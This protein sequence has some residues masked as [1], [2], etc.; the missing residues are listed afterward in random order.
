MCTSAPSAP[1][2]SIDWTTQGTRFTLKPASS[3]ATASTIFYNYAYYDSAGS[4][5]EK[6]SSWNSVSGSSES[7]Y[8]A[9]PLPGK[10]KIAFSA[11]A[12]NSCGA[13]SFTRENTTNTG[14]VFSTLIQ[15]EIMVDLTK[16]R[17]QVDSL[18]IPLSTAVSSKHLMALTFS[19]NTEEICTVS[20]SLLTLLK[21]GICRVTV[22]SGSLN[23]I[24]SA[25]KKGVEFQILKAN[26]QISLTIPKS[27]SGSTN[28]ILNPKI[29]ST[30]GLTIESDSPSFCSVR[31]N[32]IIPLATG[33]CV[34]SVTAIEDSNYLEVKKSFSLTI[35]KAENLIEWVIPSINLVDS[36]LQVNPNF[37]FAT[38]FEADN[39]SPEVCQ[40]SE[41]MSVK[42]LKGGYCI[43]HLE[44]KDSPLVFAAT[45]QFSVKV[46]K[47]Q[48]EMTTEIPTS[49]PGGNP[50]PIAPKLKYPADSVFSVK[51]DFYCSISE[52]FL[53]G[54]NEGNCTISIKVYETEKYLGFTRTFD[55]FIQ[56]K[57]QQITLNQLSFFLENSK[58]P[59]NLQASTSS[60]LP[61]LLRSLTSKICISQGNK[62]IGLKTGECKFSVE[63]AGNNEYRAAKGK[64][65]TG[66]VF[67]D[68]I[69]IAC[70][71]GKIIKKVTAVK[72]VCPKGY[73]KK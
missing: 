72:P 67:M 57:D 42:F 47:L 73:K 41:A 63:Q 43:I 19:S 71:K 30:N 34:F 25:G 39:L 55:I 6:W 40:L 36:V 56:K 37:K 21:P 2:L 27:I 52:K 9:A 35:E 17:H 58:G 8:V 50:I 62:I 45:R 28:Y 7:I 1:Q 20:S 53:I 44:T 14:V 68:K 15:D 46:S 51:D 12:A 32:E 10:S 13:S 64:F 48:N 38:D 23:N 11:Y 5:W 29:K 66:Q 26:N 33:N 22:S 3:G 4:T 59:I 31:D 69:E 16:L 65:I 54:I 61:L 49:L 70:V 60:G 18:P 24:S